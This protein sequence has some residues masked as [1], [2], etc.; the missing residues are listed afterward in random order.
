MQTFFTNKILIIYYKKKFL[1]K[2]TT[3]LVQ[4]YYYKVFD[5]NGQVERERVQYTGRETEHTFIFTVLMWD[6]NNGQYIVPKIQ[7]SKHFNRFEIAN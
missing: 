3:T 1:K 5:S 2:M 4:E 7:I 6:P